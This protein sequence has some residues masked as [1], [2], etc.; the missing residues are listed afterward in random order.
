M[1][2]TS[3]LDLAFHSAI[4]DTPLRFLSDRPGQTSEMQADAF[5]RE[6][7]MMQRL[8]LGSFFGSRAC[9]CCLQA[10]SCLSSFSVLVDESG[11]ILAWALV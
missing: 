3:V 5:W 11:L 8:E 2:L 1:F 6:S 10:V 9:S 4:F 7:L